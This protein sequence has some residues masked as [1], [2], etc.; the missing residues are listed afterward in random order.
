MHVISANLLISILYFLDT[1]PLG[2]GSIIVIILVLCLAIFV[3]FLV[4][5]Y[6][7]HRNKLVIQ[8]VDA[9]MSVLKKKKNVFIKRECKK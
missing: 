5:I 8:R 1:T 6:Q 2:I 7:Q 9:G 3:I 4:F